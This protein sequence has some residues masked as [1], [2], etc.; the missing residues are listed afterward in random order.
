MIAAGQPV[1]KTASRPAGGGRRFSLDWVG[2]V[3][4][5]AYAALF[6][7]LPTVIVMIGA[8]FDKDGNL[9][10]ANLNYITRP[11]IVTASRS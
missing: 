9:T 6:L 8:F 5:L 11:F 3:P 4:F 2:A 10:L 7:L 1:A